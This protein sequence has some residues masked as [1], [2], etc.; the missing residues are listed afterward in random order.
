MESKTPITQD[1]RLFVSVG[2]VIAVL[3]SKYLGIELDPADLATIAA[4]VI[5]YVTNSAVK[6]AKVAGANAAAAVTT[7]AAAVSIINSQAN[8]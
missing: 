4:I 2:G 1:K 8:P 6:E 3:A 7:P 5:G